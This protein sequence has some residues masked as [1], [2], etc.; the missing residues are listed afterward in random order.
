MALPGPS[1][2]VMGITNRRLP[3]PGKRQ[4]LSC[5]AQRASDRRGSAASP[6]RFERLAA[7]HPRPGSRLSS[8]ER[9]AVSAAIEVRR[10]SRS[11]RPRSCTVSRIHVDDDLLSLASWSASLR[12]SGQ[13]SATTTSASCVESRRDRGRALYDCIELPIL[14]WDRR[15]HPPDDAP[16]RPQHERTGSPP[17]AA[18]GS[19]TPA[20][21]LP[22]ACTARCPAA[23]AR[24]RNPGLS[25]TSR[26]WPDG[27]RRDG[28]VPSA[29][30]AGR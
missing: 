1:A 13:A 17:A 24:A 9:R 7:A 5:T 4:A 25:S 10:R 20:I 23:P 14:W 29:Q 3:Q 11:G 28:A 16:D 6:D 27:S 22:P 19:P 26:N 15:R 12:A 30:S 21:G 8:H 18:R 2:D